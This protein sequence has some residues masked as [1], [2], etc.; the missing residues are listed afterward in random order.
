[1]FYSHPEVSYVSVTD[2]APDQVCLAVAAFR[3][4]PVVSDFLATTLGHIHRWSRWRRRR[5]HRTK[6][7]HYQRRC[8]LHQM[9]LEY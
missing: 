1:M 8:R 6:T 2:L 4:S 3:T 9:R 7:A 5:Q